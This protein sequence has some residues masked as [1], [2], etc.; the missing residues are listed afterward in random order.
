MRNKTVFILQWIR[1]HSK[2][3]NVHCTHFFFVSLSCACYLPRKIS[4]CMR[5]FALVPFRKYFHSSLLHTISH[6]NVEWKK[7]KMLCSGC[8]FT[9]ELR[10]LSCDTGI[11]ATFTYTNTMI[12][13][14]LYCL[15]L[16]LLEYVKYFV[17][18]EKGIPII[19][20]STVKVSLWNE[21]HTI[22]RSFGR[23]IH[24]VSLRFDNQ[25]AEIFIGNDF[26]QNMY[27]T[28]SVYS[29]R[30]SDLVAEAVAVVVVVS[31]RN[32]KVV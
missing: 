22:N 7:I 25:C 17:F 24:S 10:I 14:I 32:V 28:H 30:Y 26:I 3:E 1:S 6:S 31:F 29:M 9:C 18:C 8:T 5:I 11:I 19:H 23:A 21:L 4:I 15:T 20:E 27:Y 12:H 2:R 13:S 16:L